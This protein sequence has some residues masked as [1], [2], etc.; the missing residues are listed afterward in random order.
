MALTTYADLRQ[1]LIDWPDLA[2][3]TDLESYADTLITLGEARINVSLRLRRSLKTE[4]VTGT[5]LYRSPLPE[6]FLEVDQVQTLEGVPLTYVTVD[7]LALLAQAG[8]LTEVIYYSIDGQDLVFACS[9]DG[10]V[11][12]Y[13]PLLP[14]LSTTDT[15]WVYRLSPGLYLY[16]ALIDAAV[17]SKESE[18]E[19][20]RYRAMFESAAAALEELDWNQGSPESQ[21]I[22]SRLGV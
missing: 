3:E 13:Y 17:F 15:N 7:Q 6:D 10:Y 8:N 11:L 16:S 12:R 20:A 4:T 22:V 21:P 18:Q 5:G 1:A 9:T 2:G 14:P 19:Q